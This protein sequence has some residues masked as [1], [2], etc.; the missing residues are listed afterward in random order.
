MNPRCHSI[1]RNTC[2]VEHPGAQ[3]CVLKIRQIAVH[4]PTTLPCTVH[5]FPTIDAMDDKVAPVG[6]ADL[7]FLADLLV[8]QLCRS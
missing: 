3:F 5:S 4:P 8:A 1:H 7:T 2:V 6:P